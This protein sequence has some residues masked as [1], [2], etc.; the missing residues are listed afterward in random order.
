M[1]AGVLLRVNS[2]EPHF[3]PS[4]PLPPC[5]CVLPQH[6]L[7]NVYVRRVAAA[8]ERVRERGREARQHVVGYVTSVF[9]FT[10]HPLPDHARPF[11]PTSDLKP[12]AN[13]SARAKFYDRGIAFHLRKGSSYLVP[14][15]WL[16]VSYPKTLHRNKVH[17]M[18]SGYHYD[19][20]VPPHPVNE[21]PS[22]Q[23]TRLKST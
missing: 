16:V 9:Y 10:A 4:R 6:V 18:E 5:R 8:A 3:P 13:I 15:S 17:D 1:R 20:R 2:N 23:H 19:K 12:P 22:S 11:P 21:E 14:R 7:R